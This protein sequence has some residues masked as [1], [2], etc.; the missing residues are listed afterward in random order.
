VAV[1][2]EPVR[3]S[4]VVSVETDCSER[5][6]GHK[7][8]QQAKSESVTHSV[9]LKSFKDSFAMACE[10]IVKNPRGFRE[11]MQMCSAKEQEAHSARQD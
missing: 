9:L 10:E 3:H 5:G 7:R 2:S 11:E 4:K 1:L 6:N 8:K